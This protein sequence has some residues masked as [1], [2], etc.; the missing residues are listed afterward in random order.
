MASSI[1]FLKLAACDLNAKIYRHAQD[2]M[3][4]KCTFFTTDTTEVPSSTK[5]L[6]NTPNFFKYE[7]MWKCQITQ[8][9]K[10][11]VFQQYLCSNLDVREKG[12]N[13][14]VILSA[15]NNTLIFF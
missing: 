15:S 9:N 7:V 12:I 8:L 13:F 2:L 1:M 3:L 10:T 4:M 14:T 5:V 11:Y 6:Q